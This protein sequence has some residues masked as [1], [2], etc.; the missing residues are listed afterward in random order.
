VAP[1]VVDEMA[2]LALNNG[3]AQ[4]VTSFSIG[5]SHSVTAAYSGDASH[6]GSSGKSVVSIPYTTGS[7]PG[8]YSVTITATSGALTHSSVLTLTVN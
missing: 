7:M 8:T 6:N 2:P 4:F 5:G 3:T 1:P